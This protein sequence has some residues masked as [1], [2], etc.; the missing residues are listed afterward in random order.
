MAL[1]YSY[2]FDEVAGKAKSRYGRDV[3]PTGFG[4]YIQ[5]KGWGKLMEQKMGAK[6]TALRKARGMTQEQLAAALGVSGPAVSKW[7]TGSSC[8]DIMLLCPL[9][10]VLGTNVDTLLSFEEELSQEDL[11]N[12]MGEI[13]ELAREG[14][15]SRAEERLNG[16]LHRY[17]TD[18]PLKFSAIAALSLFNMNGEDGQQGTAGGDTDRWTRQKKDLAQ[19]LC[20]S[21]DPAYYFHALSILVSL[22]LEEGELEE[23]EKLLKENQTNTGDFTALWVRLYLKRGQRDQ[24]LRALQRQAYKLVY[25]L[26]TCLMG[27]L[28]EEISPEQDRAL[29]IC[30]I[31]EQIDSLF[32]VGGNMGAGL[33]AEVYLRVGEQEKALVCLE[34]LADRMTE[35]MDPPN[36]LV[37]A[38]SIAPEPEKLVINREIRQAIL[39]GLEKDACFEPLRGRERFQVLLRKVAESLEPEKK[40]CSF[41]I[42]VV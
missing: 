6:I 23:A 27:L 25:D 22:H 7:E 5:W 39:Q 19:A 35:R 31:L 2:H 30:R 37:F 29:E 8:P 24:A 14:K 38:P 26:R 32:S 10:R 9:A 3:L 12:Y 18:I 36:P 4:L 20:R 41:G 15:I 42:E 33:A 40:A 34:R 21:G 11:E 17:P 1:Y 28:G 13:I 16:L